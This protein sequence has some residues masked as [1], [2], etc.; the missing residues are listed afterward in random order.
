M[1]RF[2]ETILDSLK[3]LLASSIKILPG[4]LVGLVIIILTN[5]LAKF[6][7]NIATK[8]GQRTIASKSLQL[9]FSKT[10]FVTAWVIGVLIAAVLAF[11]GL[12]LGD[13]IATLGLG[14]VA[15]GFAFQDIFRNFLAGILLLLQEPFR[16]GDRIIVGEYEGTV[17]RVDIRTT[18]IRTYEGERVLL[19]NA[20]VFTSAVQVRTAY[21]CRRSDLA[22]GVD[23]NTP[24]PK[25]R[26]ILLELIYEVNGVLKVPK[27]EIDLVSFGDSSID[28][29]I[30][31]WTV[32]QQSEVRRTQ[33]QAIIAIKQ[34][35]DK[36]GINIP[37]P[38]RTLYYYNQDRYN[39]YIPDRNN[40]SAKNGVNVN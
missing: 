7:R 5:Y 29:V 35:F 23:Y 1:D 17:E 3:E 22:V 20:K 37:Y 21:N 31:Y 18:K 27:A 10:A 6:V 33:S 2:V 24:L 8:I 30:R 13:I 11:P 40:N 16:I 36:A 19:P 34:A 32:P 14:S 15:V 39:D 25:A 4:I 9:L 38:I 12:R 26:D 28:L